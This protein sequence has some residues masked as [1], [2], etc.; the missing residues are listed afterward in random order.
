MADEEPV[1]YEVRGTTAIITLNRPQYRNAQNSALLYAL[2]DAFQRFAQDDD[3]RV[4]VLTGAGPHFSSGHDLGSPGVD[5]DVPY[6]RRSTWWDHT[7][8]E[9]AERWMS[10]EMEMYLGMCRRWHDLPKPTIA[11]VRGGCI[12][13]GLMLAWS[14]DLI[15]AADDAFFSDP[16]VALGCPG[17]EFFRHPW[18]LGPR[19]AK[20]FLF[21]GEAIDADRA[22]RLGMV[23]RVVTGDAL[24]DTALD[25]AER[26]GGQP[27]FGLALAKQ[28]V[29]RCE[30]AMGQ[31]A[32]ID[33]TFALHQL[34][35]AHN[36]VVSGQPILVST[37]RRTARPAGDE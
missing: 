2:D 12:A 23:N 17:V 26:I 30:E 9:G 27:A 20:E 25:M 16:V 24:L 37:P 22:H 21:L 33:A 7:D 8:K 3:V 1:L 28:A 19:Q 14:C 31:R 32:G 4:A 29:N 5:Y 10:H 11:A 13:G 35:H 15:V 18:E 36:Q 34:S 6:T